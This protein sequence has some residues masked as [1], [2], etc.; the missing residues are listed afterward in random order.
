MASSLDC[1]GTFTR[2]VK[3]AAYLYDI[4]NGE[5]PLESSSLSGK[6]AI[7]PQIWETKDLSGI[8]I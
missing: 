2:N 6:D 8:K 7:N 3:D 1:P 5:D 4:M